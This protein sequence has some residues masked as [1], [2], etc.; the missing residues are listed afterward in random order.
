MFPAL[1]SP[2]PVPCL[3]GAEQSTGTGEVLHQLRGDTAVVSM[4]AI[5]SKWSLELN[6]QIASDLE[7]QVI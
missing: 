5:L 2:A 4:T 7:S 3:L 6:Q 1:S